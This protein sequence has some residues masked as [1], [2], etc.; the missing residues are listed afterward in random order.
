[1]FLIPPSTRNC[2]IL[3][4]S[5]FNFCQ[6]FFFLFLLYNYIPTRSLYYN[7]NKKKCIIYTTIYYPRDLYH[8]LHQLIHLLVLQQMI[9]S[10]QYPPA[11]TRSVKC[12]Q[13]Q[14]YYVLLNAFSE[15]HGLMKAYCLL[16]PLHN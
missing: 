9:N 8:P 5:S 1:M 16:K 7:H 12:C 10:R 3:R 15:R 6:H 4:L 14:S 11:N 13:I 2:Y